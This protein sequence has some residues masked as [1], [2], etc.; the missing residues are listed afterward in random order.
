MRPSGRMVF[1]CLVGPVALSRIH[2]HSGPRSIRY[3][4]VRRPAGSRAPP[5]RMRVGLLPFSRNVRDSSGVR[6]AMVCVSYPRT[7]ARGVPRERREGA[8]HCYHTAGR[9]GQGG[10][11]RRDAEKP[12]ARMLGAGPLA[13]PHAPNTAGCRGDLPSCAHTGCGLMRFCAVRC[14]TKRGAQVS[15]S[16]PKTRCH[17]NYRTGECR[18]S[19]RM[20]LLSMRRR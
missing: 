16:P 19:I 15:R 5:P 13:Y 6:R 9:G 17:W 12:R 20:R 8:V 7:P 11:V 2:R 3:N 1:L 18:K 4:Q 10:G 14:G